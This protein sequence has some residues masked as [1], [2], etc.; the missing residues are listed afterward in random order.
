MRLSWIA[1]FILAAGLVNG[2]EPDDLEKRWYLLYYGAVNQGSVC[3]WIDQAFDDVQTRA[4]GRESWRSFIFNHYRDMTTEFS[5]EMAIFLQ[6]KAAAI[7][8]PEID[9]DFMAI[10][11]AYAE[12]D[13]VIPL[14]TLQSERSIL[15]VFSGLFS[16]NRHDR[17]A[18]MKFTEELNKTP[19]EYTA[20]IVRFVPRAYCEDALDLMRELA[21][22]TDG[23]STSSLRES[24]AALELVL[25]SEKP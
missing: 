18:W 3:E 19:I 11:Q 5:D 21:K 23:E 10:F 6:K 8:N 7:A 22:K 20:I 15:T 1:S 4:L 25:S 12:L 17:D 9:K 24:R 14:P 13:G 2:A 16:G